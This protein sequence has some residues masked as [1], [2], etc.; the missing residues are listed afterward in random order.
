MSTDF[1]D[2]ETTQNTHTT[3]FY[4]DF[5]SLWSPGTEQYSEGALVR[6]CISPKVH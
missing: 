6:R 4:C 2:Y 3:T 1:L 5:L